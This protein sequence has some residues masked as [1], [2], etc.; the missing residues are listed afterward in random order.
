[1]LILASQ[2]PRRRE[3]FDRLALDYKAVSKDT[4]ETVAS[5]EDPAE[6]VKILA[7][8][9]AL[10]VKGN[11]TDNDFII[12][13]DTVVALGNEIFGK[14]TDYADAFRMLRAFSGR[15]HKVFTA[16]AICQG[17]RC[18]TEAVATEV[19]FRTLSDEEIHYY[20]EHEK[21]FDKAGAYGIQEMAG[22]FVSEIR[23]S[24]DNV[25]G[26]P[27]TQLEL[28]MRR[29]FKSSLFRFAKA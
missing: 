26:L 27:Q 28:A 23:G 3:M 24:F 17:G 2:S 20:I 7:E 10:A 13:A 6:Y 14:P 5:Y 22:I 19:Y 12:A 1:M 25:V 4:D 15:A 9:K 8:R 18:Y 29:E 11:Y 16:F 21:P